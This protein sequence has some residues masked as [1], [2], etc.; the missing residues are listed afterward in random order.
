VNDFLLCC[1]DCSVQCVCVSRS[2]IQTLM[3][4][5][6]TLQY[7]AA[8]TDSPDDTS[9]NENTNSTN[10]VADS[11]THSLPTRRVS[12]SHTHSLQPTS[13]QCLDE[14]LKK[15]AA[16]LQSVHQ[17]AA[18]RELQCGD[19]S[20]PRESAPNPTHSSVV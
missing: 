20:Q 19:E 6:C 10:T 8:D 14:L 11:H 17:S 15:S 1:G 12:D 18:A 5:I 4:M 13:I 2:G 16:V 9:T 3:D 7:P